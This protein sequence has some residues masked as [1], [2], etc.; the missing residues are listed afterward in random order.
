MRCDADN[1]ANASTQKNP[2]DIVIT[3][4]IRTPLAKGKKGGLKDTPLDGIVFKL[5]EQVVFKSR[6]DP[7]LVEDV[8]LGNV[9]HPQEAT[10]GEQT[11]MAAKRSP[12][13]RPHTTAVL[14]CSPQASQPPPLAPQP[15]A[16]VHPVSRPCKTLPTRSSPEASKSV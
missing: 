11:L 7:Q 1:H 14:R 4:A 8:C 2:D 9:R 3:L 12:M 16:S 15:T 6:L 5:L 10:Q 13:Q